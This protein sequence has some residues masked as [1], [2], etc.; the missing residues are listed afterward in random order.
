MCQIWTGVRSWSSGHFLLALVHR[1]LLLALI[2][3]EQVLKGGIDQEEAIQ[4]ANLPWR[5]QTTLG[6]SVRSAFH[7]NEFKSNFSHEMIKISPSFRHF[8]ALCPRHSAWP[9][10]DQLPDPV[11]PSHPPS[12][13][14]PGHSCAAL[15]CQLAS[16]SS[17]SG[18]GWIGCTRGQGILLDPF[19]QT[20]LWRKQAR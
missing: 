3:R 6:H 20:M 13:P 5:S 16:Q 15:S 10:P 1:F 7:F 11:P 17:A 18:P 8:P 19:A 4:R 2:I 14:F 12:P 9:A